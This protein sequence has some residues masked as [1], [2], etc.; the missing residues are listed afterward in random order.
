MELGPRNLMFVW[1]G[2]EVQLDRLD[3][4]TRQAVYD[5]RGNYLY[6]ETIIVGR[7]KGKDQCPKPSLSAPN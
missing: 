2:A 7:V 5:E 1:H 4:F 3:K 6:T